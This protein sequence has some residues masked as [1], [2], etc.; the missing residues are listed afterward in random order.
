MFS[1]Y[2]L[3]LQNALVLACITHHLLVEAGGNLAKCR[4]EAE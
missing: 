4:W 3:A 1:S 2:D